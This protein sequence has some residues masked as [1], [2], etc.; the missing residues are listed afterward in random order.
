M[1]HLGGAE[2]STAKAVTPKQIRA[3][4]EKA[5][6]GQAVFAHYLNLTVGYV[7]QLERGAK[8]PCIGAARCDPPKGH[9]GN[10]VIHRGI[11]GLTRWHASGQEGWPAA[12]P[13]T[14]RH[15]AHL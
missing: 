13:V 14:P 6:L 8:R 3:M 9:R 15:R 5:N 10:L 12:A 1:R 2:R 4:R 11:R 7:S